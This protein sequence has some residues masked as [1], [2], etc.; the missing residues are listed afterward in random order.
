LCTVAIPS[1]RSKNRSSLRACVETNVRL[2][3]RSGTSA[4]ESSTGV[5]VGEP[6]R[7][8]VVGAGCSPLRVGS[9]A[10]AWLGEGVGIA[11]VGA[12]DGGAAVG[13]MLIEG[14][15]VGGGRGVGDSVVGFP[16]G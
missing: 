12:G 13:D 10:I 6:V 3:S 5:R 11:A 2:Y 9:G 8:G 4:T 1:T 14:D 7:C 16:R 15:C